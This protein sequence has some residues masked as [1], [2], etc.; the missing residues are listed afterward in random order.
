MYK[1]WMKCY[2]QMETVAKLLDQAGQILRITLLPEL[3]DHQNSSKDSDLKFNNKIASK[4]MI[5]T[6]NY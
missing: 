2:H 4:K 1:R 6:I 5:R 3:T